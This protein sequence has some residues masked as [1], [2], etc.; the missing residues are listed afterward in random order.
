MYIAMNRFQV[1]PGREEVFE[2]HWRNRESYLH[3]VDGFTEFHL[4]RGATNEECTTYISHSVWESEE[5]FGDWTESEAFRK[6]HSQARAPQGTYLGPPHFEGY[7]VI[8]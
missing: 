5:S 6:A 4:L 2:E 1:T 3:E 8:L 7:S